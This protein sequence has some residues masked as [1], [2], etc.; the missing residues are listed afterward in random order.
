ME[1][2]KRLRVLKMSWQL[3][4]LTIGQIF[5][6]SFVMHSHGLGLVMGHD[7][8]SLTVLTLTSKNYLL[9]P[10][11]TTST[12]LSFLLQSAYLFSTADTK[13]QLPSHCPNRH[14]RYCFLWGSNVWRPGWY[15][16]PVGSQSATIPG[17]YISV[18][19][20][21]DHRLWSPFRY[22]STESL[23]MHVVFRLS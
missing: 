5:L 21:S 18:L 3:F 12:V 2:E 16:F 6:E 15:S 20:S 11:R 1:L 13:Y 9:K 19:W 7:P 8:I 22:G 4:S 17:G 10:P 14:I 23:N